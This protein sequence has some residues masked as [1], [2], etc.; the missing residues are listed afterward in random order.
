MTAV[1][2]WIKSNVFTVIFAVVM[3]AALAALPIFSSRM[4]SDVKEKVENRVGTLR[5]LEGLEKTKVTIP[6]ARPGEPA[7]QTALV[8][9]R[10]LEKIQQVTDADREDA[11]NILAKAVEHNRLGRGVL[12]DTLFP[13]PPIERRDVLPRQFYEVLLEQYKALLEQVNAGSPPTLEEMRE[14]IEHRRSQFLTQTLQKDDTDPLDDEEAAQLKDELTQVRMGRYAEAADRVGLYLSIDALNVPEW[15]TTYQPT[16]SELFEWQWRYWIIEDLLMALSDANSQSSSASRAPVKRVLDLYV[17]EDT[18]S[19]GSTG[20]SSGGGS[21]MGAGMGQGAPGRRGPAGGGGGGG[22]AAV[23][24]DPK[25]QVSLDYLVSFTGRKTN[26][27]YDVRLVAMTLVVESARLPQVLDAL[28]RRNVITV[29]DLSMA[30]ADPYEAVMDGYIYGTE[31]VCELTL[32]IE[33]IWLRSWTSQFMPEEVK[34]ALGVPREP[35]K[36]PAG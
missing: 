34:I 4:N 5:K 8:N 19:S 3:V 30:P 13:D 1:L 35:T 6:G 11:E 10:L 25:K 15:V 14:E 29:L 18:S 16:M 31:P 27:L 24:P 17:Y 33:T 9:Q 2:D 26:P 23:P 20:G 22:D 7:S 32:S 28:A 12:M 21:G 36:Q